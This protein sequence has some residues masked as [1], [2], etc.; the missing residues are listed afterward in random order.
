MLAVKVG[1]TCPSVLDLEKLIV[2]PLVCFA[3]ADT[4]DLLNEDHWM[5]PGEEL[6]YLS[7]L[8]GITNIDPELGIS[9]RLITPPVATTLA[10]LHV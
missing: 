1:T 2:W 7:P 5:S 8:E 6:V 9:A 3:T 10:S 4:A